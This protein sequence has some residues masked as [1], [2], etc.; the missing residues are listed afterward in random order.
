[1]K[2][3]YIWREPDVDDQWNVG[4][5]DDESGMFITHEVAPT[6][7]GALAWLI[8]DQTKEQ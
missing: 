1:M 4:Y 5:Y 6:W 3:G 2:K 7:A 8:D